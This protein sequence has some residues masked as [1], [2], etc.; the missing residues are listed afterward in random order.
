ML[1][2]EI[3]LGLGLESNSIRGLAFRIVIQSHLKNR[4]K[5]SRDFMGDEIMV[6]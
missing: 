5:K 1:L 2:L 6:A 3:G 4:L